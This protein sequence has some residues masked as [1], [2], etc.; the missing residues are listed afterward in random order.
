[1]FATRDISNQTTCVPHQDSGS[2]ISLKFESFAALQ[3]KPQ[4]AR[5]AN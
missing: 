3:P 2:V 4:T 5:A 1:M